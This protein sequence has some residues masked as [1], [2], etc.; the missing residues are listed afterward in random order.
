MYRSTFPHAIVFHGAT[1]DAARDGLRLRAQM[2]RVFLV[3]ADGQWRTLPELSRLAQGSEAGV[4]ARLRDLRKPSFGGF[5]VE[6]RHVSNG[7]WKYR[8]VLPDHLH[9]EEFQQAA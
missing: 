4:S 5:T 2:S 7:L 3:M 6:R 9:W 8:L 1:F